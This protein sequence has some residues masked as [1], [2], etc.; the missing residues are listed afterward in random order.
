MVD[1]SIPREFSVPAAQIALTPIAR[2]TIPFKGTDFQ[3]PSCEKTRCRV[4]IALLGNSKGLFVRNKLLMRIAT[5]DK[6]DT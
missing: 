1:V 5:M 6:I 2:I 3:R 4:S